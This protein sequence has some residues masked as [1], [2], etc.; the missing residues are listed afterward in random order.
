MIDLEEAIR[1]AQRIR[2]MGLETSPIHEVARRVGYKNA[3]STPFYRRMTAARLF[4][5]LEAKALLSQRAL[6][7]IKPHD[8]QMK[9]RVLAE[10]ILGIP[11]YAE[12]HKRYVGKKL[13]VELLANGIAKDFHFSDDCA[14]TC[15]KTFEAS[16]RFA[17]MLSTDGVVCGP[18]AISPQED[19]GPQLQPTA[20]TIEPDWAHLDEKQDGVETQQHTLF[21]DKDKAKGRRFSFVGPLAISRAEY[22][23]ICRWLEVQMI[24]EAVKENQA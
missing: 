1:I 9:A 11:A 16:L 17:G 24:V 5:L 2:D 4:G 18:V 23:R 22:E 8:E 19:P 10:A 3:T 14:R 20:P 7:Y 13:N 6:D 15:A 12:L 21:L